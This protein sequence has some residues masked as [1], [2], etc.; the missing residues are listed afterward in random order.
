VAINEPALLVEGCR[1]K[2][3]PVAD[4]PII[5]AIGASVTIAPGPV[6]RLELEA[7]NS[8]AAPAA[9]HVTASLRI[10]SQLDLMSRVPR[11]PA[12][13][14]WHE[15]FALTLQPGE[16]KVIP[17]A[18]GATLNAMG[19]ATVTLESGKQRINVV[20]FSAVAP[21]PVAGKPVAVVSP[22]VKPIVA[23]AAGRRMP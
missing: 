1:V 8:S 22:G 16:I 4:T 12:A 20:T 18:T 6:P 23:Q 14:V 13:P 21:R 7:T 19:V 5:K 11:P 9:I 15:E 2:V 17:I 10:S 3:R